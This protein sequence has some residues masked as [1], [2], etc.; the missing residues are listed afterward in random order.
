M[1]VYIHLGKGME[2]SFTECK[3]IYGI[4]KVKSWLEFHNL[5]YFLNRIAEFVL[6]KVRKAIERQIYAGYENYTGKNSDQSTEKTVTGHPLAAI[7]RMILSSGEYRECENK[8][9]DISYEIKCDKGG[10]EYKRRRKNKH[11]SL[12]YAFYVGR[13]GDPRNIHFHN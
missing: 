6:H 5:I 2:Q 9:N 8:I 11:V 12:K 4:R 7:L 10:E 3:A 1:I 13:R